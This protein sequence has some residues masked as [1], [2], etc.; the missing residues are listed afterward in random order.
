MQGVK[1]TIVLAPETTWA[2]SAHI[3]HHP[4]PLHVAMAPMKLPPSFSGSSGACGNSTSPREDRGHHLSLRPPPPPR[5]QERFREG[6]K[7]PPNRRRLPSNRRRLPSNRRGF[8]P[9]YD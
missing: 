4:H 8:S 5:Y 1:G 7:H 2:I 3:A 6:P 9:E